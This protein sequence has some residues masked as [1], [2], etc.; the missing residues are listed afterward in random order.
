MAI[1]PAAASQNQQQNDKQYQYHR[2]SS[3]LLIF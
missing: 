1:V 2:E 3:F